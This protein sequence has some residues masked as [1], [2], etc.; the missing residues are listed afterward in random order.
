VVN[1]EFYTLIDQICD[2]DP[3][4]KSDAYEFLME[5]LAYTQRRY[6]R[7]KHVSG[8]ELLEG[9]KQLLMHKFGPLTL[10]VLNHWGIKSTEDF[11]N[12]VFNLVDNKIL[13]KDSEDN[14][15]SFQNGYDFNEVFDR[16]Y[17]KQL[18]KRISRMRSS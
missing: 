12:I 4:Y 17:R 8:E 15:D 11:G 7:Y 9:I 16:G 5:A 10:L 3:R 2:V 18:E 14:I 6:K 1:Q 13:S